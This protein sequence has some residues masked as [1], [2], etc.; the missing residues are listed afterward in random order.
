[1]L[2][3]I[4]NKQLK[5]AIKDPIF[6]SDLY[7]PTLISKSTQR[8]HLSTITDMDSPIV[9]CSLPK[10]SIL[11]AHRWIS[12]YKIQFAFREFSRRALPPISWS[13]L[14]QSLR[15]AWELRY[16]PANISAPFEKIPAKIYNIIWDKPPG[17]EHPDPVGGIEGPRKKV[18]WGEN[19]EKKEIGGPR[20]IKT[21]FREREDKPMYIAVKILKATTE[22]EI[23]TPIFS[24]T[25][26]P[27]LRTVH[28][29]LSKSLKIIEMRGRYSFCDPHSTRVYHRHS[30]AIRVSMAKIKG[31]SKS[32]RYYNPIYAPLPHEN[33]VDDL[34]MRFKLLEAK[35]E[36]LK[37]HTPP[38]KSSTSLARSGPTMICGVP[39]N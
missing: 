14:D 34:E 33:P 35:I 25:P 13:I 31:Y 10:G 11:Y 22:N 2:T 23:L 5:T 6:A 16:Q 9:H 38:H 17:S 24:T 19:S 26:I 7:N 21:D 27:T 30:G 4:F 29:I 32:T 28:N 20:Q 12:A 18:S 8:P 1:M 39:R 37:I 36:A 3:L 15:D